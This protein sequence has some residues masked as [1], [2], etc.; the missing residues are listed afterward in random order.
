M[1]DGWRHQLNFFVV[2]IL[3]CNKTATDH[4]TIQRIGRDVAVFVASF[5]GTPIMEVQRTVFAAA[6]RGYGAAVLLCSV[7][8]IGNLIVHGDVI[9]LAGR[10]VEPGAPSLSSVARDD[11]ALI[12]TENH[13]LGIA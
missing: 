2:H 7:D 3:A 12:A 1:S 9:K 5:D 4:A 10:L 13:S 8:P 6:R 11:C